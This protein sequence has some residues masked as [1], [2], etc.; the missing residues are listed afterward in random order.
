MCPQSGRIE[1]TPEQEADAK[2]RER[3]LSKL[4]ELALVLTA[5]A[6]DH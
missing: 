1:R 6:V 3:K 4:R 2:G 5:D